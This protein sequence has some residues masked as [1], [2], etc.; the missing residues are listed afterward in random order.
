MADGGALAANGSAGRLANRLA[1]KPIAQGIAKTEAMAAAM[2][3]RMRAGQVKNV[4]LKTAAKMTAAAVTSSAAAGEIVNKA[5]GAIN[6]AIKKTCG[7]GEVCP[8]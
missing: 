7:A 8:K 6:D 5:T 4:G 2:M 1:G 3:G